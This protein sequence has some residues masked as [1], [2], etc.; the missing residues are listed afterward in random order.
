M[1]SPLS[2]SLSPPPPPLRLDVCVY[3]Y[4]VYKVALLSPH[5]LVY[6][7]S[8]SLSISLALVH[9]G[10]LSHDVCSHFTVCVP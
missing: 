5:C 2:L 1:L 6:C 10:V 7:L 4:D 9:V 8:L 3:V